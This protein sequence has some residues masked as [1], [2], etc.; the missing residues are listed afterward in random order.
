M[1]SSG[2]AAI[3]TADDT[4][5]TL[6]SHATL[7]GIERHVKIT[8][9]SAV[10]GFWS[11]DNG[12]SWNRLPASGVMTAYDLT[13]INSVKVKRIAAGSNLTGLYATAW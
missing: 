11:T 5:V 13:S 4:A 10:A 8:N 1:K 12:I 6:I 9:D 7:S 3:S 2:E